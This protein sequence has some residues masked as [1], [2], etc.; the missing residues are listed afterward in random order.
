MESFWE[1]LVG[2]ILQYAGNHFPAKFKSF[3][4]KVHKIPMV[5]RLFVAST[6]YITTPVSKF[7]DHILSP[8]LPTRPS[9]VRDSTAFINDLRNVQIHKDC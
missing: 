4:P 8:L 5:G 6:R 1:K 3:L 2:Y 9:Y 7:I